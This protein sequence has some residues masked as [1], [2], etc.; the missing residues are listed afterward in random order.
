[1]R[2]GGGHNSMQ[3]QHHNIMGWG[4]L[5]NTI[6]WGAQE[7]LHRDALRSW[8]TVMSGGRRAGASSA[9]LI[10]ECVCTDVRGNIWC[11]WGSSRSQNH[12]LYRSV[13]KQQ[14]K[15]NML[16]Q[17]VILNLQFTFPVWT[18]W[19]IR[20]P[21]AWV[22]YGLAHPCKSMRIQAVPIKC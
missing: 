14:K 10:L 7:L 4:Y 21:N 6:F 9:R 1:M 22:G 8:P 11:K 13:K 20:G 16:K 5:I 3:W 18:M 17:H 12:V 19:C 15:T 2:L